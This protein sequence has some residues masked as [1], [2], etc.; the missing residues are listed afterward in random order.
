MFDKLTD[1][2]FDIMGIVRVW[3]VVYEYQ[4]AIVFRFGKVNRVLG[5]GIHFILPL[6]MEVVSVENI[7]KD[8]CKLPPQSVTTADNISVVLSAVVLWRVTS[9]VDFITKVESGEEA[10]ATIIAADIEFLASQC[11]WYELRQTTFGQQ[12]RAISAVQLEQ[13]GVQLLAIGFESRSQARSVR[14]WNFTEH[15]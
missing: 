11:T 12:V 7:V 10:L 4:R 15:V 5:P 3:T 1:K 14:F 13:F 6:Y 2:L 8:V 9:V